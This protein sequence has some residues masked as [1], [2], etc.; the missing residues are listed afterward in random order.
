MHVPKCPVAGRDRGGQ[1]AST[2]PGIQQWELVGHVTV[3]SVNEYMSSM[4]FWWMLYVLGHPD[5]FSYQPLHSW[6][7]LMPYVEV[8]HQSQF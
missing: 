7:S 4:R 5:I 6:N 1:L 2:Q 3:E 8:Y